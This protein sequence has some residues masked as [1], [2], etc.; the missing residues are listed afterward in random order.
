MFWHKSV[1]MALPPPFRPWLTV[2]CVLPVLMDQIP[3]VLQK[4][5]YDE[6]QAEVRKVRLEPATSQGRGFYSQRLETNP[7]VGASPQP[8][9]I[10]TWITRESDNL[11]EAERRRVMM[12]VEEGVDKVSSLLSVPRIVGPL[13]LSRDISKYC[14]FVW[15]NSGGANSNRW[16]VSYS[17]P[18]KPEQKCLQLMFISR[19]GRA[20]VNYRNE[21]CLDVTIPDQHLSGCYIYPQPDSPYRTVLRAEGSGVSDTDFLLYLHIGSTH[22]CRAEPDVWAYAA[23]CQTDTDGRPVA[24]VVVICRDRLTQQTYKHQATVQMVIHELFH[25]L[26]FSKDLFPTWTDCSTHTHGYLFYFIF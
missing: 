5:I 10:H 19:C 21:T 26:G 24:A 3:G 17:T 9:R 23:H 1:A 7:R 2:V 13:L 4:C 8:I 22:K 16:V 25:V 15:S 20:N 18:E 14:K 12:A 11:P 6:V